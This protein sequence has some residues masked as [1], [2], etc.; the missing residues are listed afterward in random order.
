ML[1]CSNNLSVTHEDEEERKERKD[2]KGNE[3][4]RELTFRA[5]ED[6]NRSVFEKILSFF[7]F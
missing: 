4:R 5:D 2:K 6:Q 3:K 1:N 7:H